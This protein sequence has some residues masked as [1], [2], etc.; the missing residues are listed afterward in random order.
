MWKSRISALYFQCVLFGG[1]TITCAYCEK[2]WQ[3]RILFSEI[4]TIYLCFY[5]KNERCCKATTEAASLSSVEL[6]FVVLVVVVHTPLERIAVPWSVFDSCAC[7]GYQLRS[8]SLPP[9]QE[10]DVQMDR[11][12]KWIIKEKL[13]LRCGSGQVRWALSKVRAISGSWQMHDR[14]DTSLSHLRWQS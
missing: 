1:L 8:P 14:T 5:V 11:H 10:G 12:V 2:L 13:T 9:Q 7:P 6:W 4:P 3:I